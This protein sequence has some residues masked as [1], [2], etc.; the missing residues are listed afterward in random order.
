MYVIKKKS[1]TTNSSSSTTTIINTNTNTIITTTKKKKKKKDKKK[2]TPRNHSEKKKEWDKERRNLN[3]RYSSWSARLLP[4][5]W[6][7]VT[8]ST[9]R[10]TPSALWVFYINDY[11]WFFRI[12]ITSTRRTVELKLVRQKIGK[13]FLRLSLEK[14]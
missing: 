10:H 6:T 8:V 14:A 4:I 12:T 1:T 9:T 5:D 11:L 13:K 2:N 3:V 7:V